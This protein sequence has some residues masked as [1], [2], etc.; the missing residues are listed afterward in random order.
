MSTTR[1]RR[2]EPRSLRLFGVAF[3]YQGSSVKATITDISRSGAFIHS[4][5]LPE[6]GCYLDF[7]I[8]GP[9]GSIVMV[10]GEVVRVVHE[11]SG[12]GRL[13]GFGVRWLSMRS[14]GG[15]SA[16]AEM[17]KAMGPGPIPEALPMTP[18]PTSVEYSFES[19]KFV[20]RQP[21]GP[22]FRIEGGLTPPSGLQEVGEIKL[23]AWPVR[24]PVQVIVRRGQ[25]EGE[26]LKLGRRYVLVRTSEMV[27][28]PASMVVLK[29]PEGLLGSLPEFSLLG[30]VV[31]SSPRPQRG[32]DAE[33]R[34]SSVEELTPSDFERVLEAAKEGRLGR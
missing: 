14:Q 29:V 26:I 32:G 23:Q 21:T 11:S 5:V 8:R 30:L 19:K 4:R 24:I 17:L 18:T 33:V 16:V 10:T 25:S 31:A 20:Q 27:L 9:G 12:P 15:P 3:Q 13:R 6:V 2:A 1:D 7:A 22:R 28:P 34:I